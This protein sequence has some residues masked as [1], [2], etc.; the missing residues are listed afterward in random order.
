MFSA[1]GGGVLA[2]ADTCSWT[3]IG[4]AIKAIAC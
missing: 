1:Y 3:F 2:V 4:S